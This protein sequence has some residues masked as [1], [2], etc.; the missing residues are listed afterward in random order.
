MK[1]S[2]LNLGKNLSKIKQ[3]SI[4]GGGTQSCP[5][6]NCYYGNSDTELFGGA[7]YCGSCNDY[8]N[9]PSSCQIRVRVGHYCFGV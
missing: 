2:I 5:P 9:L 8:N 4:N 7:V 6:I 3:K 1:K